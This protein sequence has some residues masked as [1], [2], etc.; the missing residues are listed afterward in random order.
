MHLWLQQEQSTGDPTPLASK[1]VEEYLA[2]VTKRKVVIGVVIEL[3]PID[4]FRSG[5]GCT[6]DNVCFNKPHLF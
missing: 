3:S 2:N 5:Q 6:C 1:N 4:N